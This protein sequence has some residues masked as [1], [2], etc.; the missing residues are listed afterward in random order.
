M[1]PWFGGVTVHEC[2]ESPEMFYPGPQL[3]GWMTENFLIVYV[4]QLFS[5][6]IFLS[7]LL[8]LLIL[9]NITNVF[10]NLCM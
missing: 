6:H 2:N 1:K 5:V 8:P 3:L 4:V 9:L 10:S 7:S